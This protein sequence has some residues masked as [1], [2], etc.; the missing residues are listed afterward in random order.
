MANSRLTLEMSRLLSDGIAEQMP[1]GSS[2][3]AVFVRETFELLLAR[4]PTMAEAT[5]C[6]ATLEH[7]REALKGK[8]DAT[9]RAKT[10]LVH[11]LLNH[12]DFV[13]IR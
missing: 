1:E 13:T 11:A 10:A 3:D 7:L 6:R 2:E 8:A 5:A 12:N 9:T 4:K